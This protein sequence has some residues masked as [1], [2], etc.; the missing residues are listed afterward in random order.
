MR[1]DTQYNDLLD[2]PS[3]WRG[4]DEVTYFYVGDVFCIYLGSLYANFQEKISPETSGKKLQ[5]FHCSNVTT[6]KSI[7]YCSYIAHILHK[8]C[9]YIAHILL[10]YCLYSAHILLKYCLYIVDWEV[11]ITIH[12][13]ITNLNMSGHVLTCTNMSK[14]VI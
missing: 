5:T 11:D 12:D 3:S 4:R 8:Y 2:R 14:R 6:M 1:P 9:S 7:V 13:E 10:T